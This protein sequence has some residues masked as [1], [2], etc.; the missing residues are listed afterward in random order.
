MLLLGI[1]IHIIVAALLTVFINWLGLIPWRRHRDAHWTDQARL[2]WPV[3][4]TAATNIFLLPVLL[5][6]IHSL[7]FPVPFYQWV[8]NLVAG[9]LGS[10]LGNFPLDRAI[11]PQLNFKN[12]L[13]QVVAWWGFRFG[14]WALLLAAILIMPFTFGW[15]MVVVIAGYL[16]VHFFLQFGAILK[17][18]RFIKFLEPAGERLQKIVDAMAARMQVNVRATWELKGTV[19][20]AFAF[21]I[22]HELMFTRR[23]LEVCNDDEVSAICAHELGHLKERRNVLVGRLAGSLSLF[24]LIFIKPAWAYFGALGLLVP[25]AGFFLIFHLSRQLSRRM[26]K[27]ADQLAQ[28]EEV[29]QGVYARALEKLYRENLSPAINATKRYTHPDLYDRME[30]AGITPDFPRPPRPKRFTII[31]WILFIAFVVLFFGTVL[32]RR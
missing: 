16:F 26:E 17:Y 29:N 30:A 11:F 28:K 9:A 13:V 1:I 15:P 27:R 19:A 3:R 23:V 6:C 18:L 25:Y 2:L 12:W 21:P 14:I 8:I 32:S 4:T 31:G 7:V 10:L 24:P 20:N 5:T 22:R